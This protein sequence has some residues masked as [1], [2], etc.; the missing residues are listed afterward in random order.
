MNKPKMNECGVCGKS[1]L[2][3]T[4]AGCL[5]GKNKVNKK[6][7]SKISC[8]NKTDMDELF[9]FPVGMDKIPVANMWCGDKGMKNK[10]LW[11]KNLKGNCGIPCGKVNGIMVVDLDLYK[12]NKSDSEFIKT[13]GDDYVEKFDT[14]TQNLHHIGKS[15]VLLQM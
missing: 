14:L 4:C 1:T 3:T 10:H 6:Q 5:M 15:N 8:N 9:K 2:L 12:L 11:R 13:F 7:E